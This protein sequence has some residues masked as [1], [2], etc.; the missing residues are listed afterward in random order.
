MAQ[1]AACPSL[2]GIAELRPVSAPRHRSGTSFRQVEQCL[3]SEEAIVAHLFRRRE[4]E[5]SLCPTCA[6]PVKL[7]PTK[8]IG[9]YSGTC[10]QA[11]HRIV[12]MDTL[13]ERSTWPLTSWIM[14]MVYFANSRSGISRAF[15]QTMFG[16]TGGSAHIICKRI[17]QHMALLEDERQ[18]GGPSEPVGLSFQRIKG[19]RGSRIQSRSVLVMAIHDASHVVPVVVADRRPSTIH[20]IVRAKVRPGSILVYRDRIEHAR[21]NQ[22]RSNWGLARSFAIEPASRYSGIDNAILVF[23]MHFRRVM[24]AGHGH[25][26]RGNLWLYLGEFAFRFNRRSEP[27]QIFWDMVSHFPPVVGR[28]A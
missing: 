20:P 27:D 11:F 23:W 17:R 10:C 28:G 6:R 9:T 16:L 5:L 3:G 1:A 8:R 24:A 21:L 4:K 18:L 22:F 2:Q 7:V 19:A 13:F 15:L 14:A 12:T 25:F 26:A